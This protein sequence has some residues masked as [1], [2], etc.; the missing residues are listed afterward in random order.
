M[1]AAIKYTN[2]SVFTTV[3][4]PDSHLISKAKQAKTSALISSFV[5][6]GMES[7]LSRSRP[8]SCESAP[9]PVIVVRGLMRTV[10]VRNVEE[11]VRGERVKWSR[12]D[13]I[14]LW[15][16]FNEMDLF[17]CVVHKLFV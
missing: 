9:G 6:F 4:T 12:N 8:R 14:S 17:I 5:S 16:V 15:S 3:S 11:V 13:V 2:D 10:V 1:Q 7:V